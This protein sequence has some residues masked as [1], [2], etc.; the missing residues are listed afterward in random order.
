MIVTLYAGL[1]NINATYPE[2]MLELNR[3]RGDN[4]TV[5]NINHVSLNDIRRSVR[6]SRLIVLDNSL[7]MAAINKSNES[8]AGLRGVVIEG[9]KPSSFYREAIEV[10]LAATQPKVFIA[11]GWDLHWR[12]DYLAQLSGRVEA[13]AWMY[14]KPPV[15]FGAVPQ[16]YRDDWMNE[17]AAIDSPEF[18]IADPVTVWNEVAETFP[19]R[20]ELPHAV[21]R[22]EL[23]LGHDQR[24]WQVSMPGVSYMTRVVGLASLR[25]A[26]LRIGPFERR[27]SVITRMAAQAQRLVGG[28]LASRWWISARG[29]NQR[30]L[31]RNSEVGCTCGSGVMYDVRKFYEIPAAGSALVCYADINLENLGFVDGKTCIYSKPEDYG[32]AVK[33]LLSNRSE[34]NRLRRAGF[35]MVRDLHSMEKRVSDFIECLR[36]MTNGRLSHASFV[37]GRY[38]IR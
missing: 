37:G 28:K 12:A 32:R 29:W 18:R 31:L 23:S 2:F 6:R 27:D 17:G 7:F 8:G 15:P 21:T 10:I 26:G 20:I 36:Q 35:E 3:R 38:Y 19:I 4:L 9:D 33:H 1:R 22:R 30:S 5:V 11:S 13:L 16:Q 24:R 25:E 14:D 34:L